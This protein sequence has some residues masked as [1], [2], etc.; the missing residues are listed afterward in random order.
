MDLVITGK[1]CHQLS[2]LATLEK[3]LIDHLQDHLPLTLFLHLDVSHQN[4]PTLC[5]RDPPRQV[6]AVGGEILSWEDAGV[7]LIIHKP[8]LL[9][10]LL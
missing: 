5:L 7:I 3:E 2:T 4:Q 8:M 6:S 10:L 9:Y 1:D